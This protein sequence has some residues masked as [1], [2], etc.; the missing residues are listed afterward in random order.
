MWSSRRISSFTSSSGSSSG[1]CRSPPSRWTRRSSTVSWSRAA[2]SGLRISC[3]SPAV[4]VPT[5]A[6]FSAIC[7]LWASARFSPCEPH[8]AHGLLHRHQQLLRGARLD[9]VGAGAG[10]H[11][12]HRRLERGEAGQQHHLA[13]GVQLLELLRQRGAVAVGELQVD[14]RHVEPSAASCSAPAQDAGRADRVAGLLEDLGEVL[15]Q[16]AVV[17][18]QQDAWASRRGLHH[19]GAPRRAAWSRS[20]AASSSAVSNG[21]LKKAGPSG[22][23]AVRKPVMISMGSPGNLRP[24]RRIAS[25]S[26]PPGTRRSDQRAERP[27]RAEPLGLQHR[28]RR[29]RREAVAP[30]RLAE[31]VGEPLI[32]LD[33]RH[34]PVAPG[35]GRAARA[36][37]G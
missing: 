23:V 7:A 14:Q 3:E 15:D 19:R 27:H 36:A 25:P 20:T 21:L 31:V 17:V 4:M 10:A 6:S 2:L 13:V 37:P 24:S 32:V 1:P 29:D 9:Q 5:A 28:P 12:R 8:L 30:Q 34:Q 11:R 18:D 22:S 16:R 33:H 35:R 26:G